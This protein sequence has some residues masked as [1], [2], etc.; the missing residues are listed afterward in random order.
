MANELSKCPKC[1]TVDLGRDGCGKHKHRRSCL[2]GLASPWGDDYVEADINWNQFCAEITTG[3]AML[4]AVPDGHQL[5]GEPL[6]SSMHVIWDTEFIPS[7]LSKDDVLKLWRKRYAKHA[8]PGDLG[9]KRLLA[10]TDA[11]L[12]EQGKDVSDG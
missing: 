2:C 10:D 5:R 11:V 1:G 7:P 4:G 9:L 12:G 6:L 8:D 3:R